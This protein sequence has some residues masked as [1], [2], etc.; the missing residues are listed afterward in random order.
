MKG[1][2]LAGRVKRGTQKSGNDLLTDTEG[3]AYAHT[4][5]NNPPPTPAAQVEVEVGVE[6]WALSLALVL[7]D[8]LVSSPSTISLSTEHTWPRISAQLAER[9]WTYG[10]VS[11]KKTLV[12]PCIM[13]PED[14]MLSEAPIL[15][16]SKSVFRK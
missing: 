8:C 10:V 14:P 12:G 13:S 3:S 2:F 4:P 1:E 9:P 7:S 16:F 15:I 6:V 5:L 11:H